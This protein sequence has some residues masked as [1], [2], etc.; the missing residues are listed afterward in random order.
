MQTPWIAP[1]ILSADFARLGEEV[2]AADSKMAARLHQVF[3]HQIGDLK[4]SAAATVTQEVYAGG[5]SALVDLLRMIRSPQS[6][7]DAV[8]MAEIL[9]RPDERW[10]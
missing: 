10:Q 1:S 8:L 9:H 7:R 6:I 4:G 3:D 5:E 2:D